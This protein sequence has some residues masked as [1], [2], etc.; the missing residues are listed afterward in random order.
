MA[1]SRNH[2]AAVT[3]AKE[4]A[5]RADALSGR[6]I[7]VT[8]VIYRPD[9][10]G[11]PQAVGS[12][13]L[14][15]IGS[16]RFVVSAAH[17]LNEGS[18]HNLYIPTGSE[19][20][21]LDGEATRIYSKGAE[22]VADDHVDVGVVRLNGE[23][24]DS[25]NDSHFTQWLEIDHDGHFLKGYAFALLGYP[26]TKQREPIEGQYVVARAYRVAALECNRRVYEQEGHDPNTHLLIGFDRRRTWGAEGPV[27]APDLYGVSG[28]GIWNFRK[29]SLRDAARPPW[30]AAIAIEWR[31]RGQYKYVLGT[32]IGVVLSVLAQRYDDVH[33]T[34]IDLARIRPN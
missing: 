12:A 28:G 27:T 19:L 10:R 6:L 2:S 22:T 26:L 15:A 18:V 11:E 31:R 4:L 14:L 34:I 8:S 17:V 30:L 25:L 16:I 32:R 3:Q 5:A 20:T 24:W 21:R 33:R 9:E 7:D 23:P 1:D 29:R 13:V